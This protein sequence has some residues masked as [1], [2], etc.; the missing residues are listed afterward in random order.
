MPSKE[1]I[2]ENIGEYSPAEIAAYI[3]SGVVSYDELCEEPEFSSLTR[4]E[5][6]E[7]LAN[8]E[9]DDWNTALSSNTIE[10]YDHY[11]QSYPEGKYRD[12]AR[13]AKRQLAELN[14]DNEI[15]TT[16]SKVDKNSPSELRDFISQ[17]PN[18]AYTSDA[19]ARL[20]NLNRRRY[21]SSAM[22]RLKSDIE[23]EADTAQVSNIIQSY[24]EEGSVTLDQIYSELKA[25]YNLLNVGTINELERRGVINFCDLEDKAGI[26]SRFLEY[27]TNNPSRLSQSSLQDINCPGIT[28]INSKTTEVY[29]WGI[30][31]SG[32][33]CAL[34][35]IMSEAQYGQYVDFAE[36]STHCQG[37][38]YMSELSQIFDGRKDVFTLPAGTATDA[39]YEMGYIYKKDRK[40]YPVTFIDL[41][42][43]TIESMYLKNA[44]L[45]LSPR[46]AAAL[47]TACSLLTGN[48]G[49]NRKIHFFVLEYDGHNKD[50]KG[51]TQ[52]TLL[53]GAMAFIKE[54]GIF[55]T[56]TDGVYLLI[57]KSDLTGA[58]SERERNEI[59]TD[60]IKTHYKQFYNGLRSICEENEVN[61][62]QVEIV[63]FSLGTVCFKKLCLFDNS[64]SKVVVELILNR[65]KGFKTGKLAKFLDKIK[66]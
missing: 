13:E 18:S 63:P 33:T 51:L 1:A 16:W 64:T 14:S 62:G 38:Q 66:K 2:I 37:Y 45:P 32:K 6:R 3:R 50:Y 8:S 7:I 28:A 55:R 36:P 42:G 31:S 39:I 19:E 57:T 43:E 60:Y 54:T 15:E 12:N 46:K 34:G 9:E 53:T 4:R 29:F 61:G 47:N 25:N 5:V 35:A 30:P 10:E 27:I 11:L 59:L 20:A 26:D 48:S 22:T 65:A 23:G 24:L 41:A 40:D 58:K 52:H 17:Y 44:K 49:I 56:E 21:A